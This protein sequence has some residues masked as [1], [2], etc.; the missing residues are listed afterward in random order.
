MHRE[1]RIAYR[2]AY[3][4]TLHRNHRPRRSWLRRRSGTCRCGEPI[5]PATRS[6]RGLTTA[7]AQLEP[8]TGV[9]G[10]APH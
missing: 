3:L 10:T 1:P 2:E 6:C 5:L 4:A 7:M 9:T 8:W